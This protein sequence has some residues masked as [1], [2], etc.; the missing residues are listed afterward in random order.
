MKQTTQAE[1]LEAYKNLEDVLASRGFTRQASGKG[2]V[3]QYEDTLP[4]ESDIRKGLQQCRI[5]RN[6]YQH[7]NRTLFVPTADAVKLLNDLVRS[8]DDRVYTK[9]IA[10]KTKKILITDKVTS[11]SEKDIDFIINGGVLPVLTADN[12]YAGGID[13][14]TLIRMLT[15]S[16][17]SQIKTLLLDDVIGKSA[18]KAALTVLDDMLVSSI[19]NDTAYVVIDTKGRYKGMIQK[20]C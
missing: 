14:H 11:I 9:D 2:L 18:R 4:P 19:S 5:I 15:A 20:Q 12:K 3:A 6:G 13:A 7:E 10:K 8:L 17:R 1:F 16:T